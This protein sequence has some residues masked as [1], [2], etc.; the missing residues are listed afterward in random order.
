MLES[1]DKETADYMVP[2]LQ[3]GLSILGMFD[4]NVRSLSINDIARQLGI[5]PS[6]C[7]RIL[8]TLNEMGYLNKSGAYYE[9][10]AS[11]ISTGFSYLASRDLVD[12]AM[13]YLNRLRDH[14]SLSSHLSIREQTESLYIYRAFAV[15]RLSV[16]IPIGTRIACHCTAMGRVLLSGLNE[17]EVD[18][19]YQNIRLDDYPAPSARTLTELQIMLAGDRDRGWVVHRSDYSTSLAAGI[20]DHTGHI[21]AA[22]NLSGPDAVMDSPGTQ[23]HLLEKLLS[24]T[25]AISTALGAPQNKAD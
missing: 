10:G 22:A 14:T 13:P 1:M 7:Y 25:Q 12:V 2:A 6:S 9:L 16:N 3:R 21:I 24:A 15:Q 18:S 5:T 23:E 11:V 17:A 20:K 4:A 8:F 19:L